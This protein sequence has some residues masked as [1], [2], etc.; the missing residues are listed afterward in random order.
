MQQRHTLCTWLTRQRERKRTEAAA[1]SPHW[2]PDL[3]GGFCSEPAQLCLARGTSLAGAPHQVQTMSHTSWSRARTHTRFGTCHHRHAAPVRGHPQRSPQPSGC[4][5]FCEATH[6]HAP[7][8]IGADGP[9]DVQVNLNRRHKVENKVRELEA[10]ASLQAQQQAALQ[11]Q[12]TALQVPPTCIPMECL[13]ARL[14]RLP[15]FKAAARCHQ[16]CGF[17]LCGLQNCMSPGL[18]A[19]QVASRHSS[20][21]PCST[22]PC[23]SACI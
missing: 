10:A 14:L 1:L 20:R 7:P 4:G 19:S 11:K 15:C 2:Q 12:Y 18:P 21:Q 22:G 8:H 9:C 6:A 13:A 5:R 17:G 3:E 23:E 16:T